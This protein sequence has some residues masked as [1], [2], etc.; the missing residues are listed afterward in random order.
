[1]GKIHVVC[2]KCVQCRVWN[3]LHRVYVPV[4][5]ED[6]EFHGSH[7]VRAGLS[8]SHTGT[9]Q[10]HLARGHFDPWLISTLILILPLY[11]VCSISPRHVLPDTSVPGSAAQMG[12]AD[13]RPPSPG[14]DHVSPPHRTPA[15]R[16]AKKQLSFHL[17]NEKK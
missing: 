14:P 8:R 1:M 17:D 5:Q 7:K 4:L 2:F 11:T 9:V 6:V 13:P 10:Q 3:C 16:G 15:G 12:P